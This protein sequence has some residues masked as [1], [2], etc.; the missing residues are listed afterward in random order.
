[1]LAVIAAVDDIIG[2]LC[3][4]FTHS[5][6][7]SLHLDTVLRFSHFLSGGEMKRRL[8]FLWSELETV[9]VSD[10]GGGAPPVYSPVQIVFSLFSFPPPTGKTADNTTDND[11]KEC[12]YLGSKP[13]HFLLLVFLTKIPELKNIY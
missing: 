12:L 8:F 13:D 7:D 4:E 9:R 2:V 10:G 3:V 1:M 11:Q 5:L 6:V